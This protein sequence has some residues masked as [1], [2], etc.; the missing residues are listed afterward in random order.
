MTRCAP[1]SGS[2][3]STALLRA[4]AVVRTVPQPLGTVAPQLSSR[5]AMTTCRLA[6]AVSLDGED[7]TAGELD[8][9]QYSAGQP[10]ASRKRCEGWGKMVI[11]WHPSALF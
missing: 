10:A 9:R 6:S 4:C 5:S 7:S 3:A 2:P 11:A 1:E 8:T